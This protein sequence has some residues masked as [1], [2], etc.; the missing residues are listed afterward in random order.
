[1]SKELSDNVRIGK[2]RK[3]YIKQGPSMTELLRAYNKRQSEESV[4]LRFTLVRS[5]DNINLGAT[6]YILTLDHIIDIHLIDIHPIG[7]CPLLVSDDG[8][9]EVFASVRCKNGETR[10]LKFSYNHL[11]QT[12]ILTVVNG[13]ELDFL[14]EQD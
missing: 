13:E 12:G 6:R 4:N 14:I 5:K 7:I 10:K 1:M 11:F 9:C 3:Y 2:L 8:D